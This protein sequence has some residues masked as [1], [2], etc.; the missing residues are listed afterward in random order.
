VNPIGERTK[1]LL[2]SVLLTLAS[3]IQALS[4]EVLWEGAQQA[5][6]LW[7]PGSQRLAGWLQVS[8][9][10]LA[11][12]LV[13]V[14]Y[15]QLV[16]R[17][18]WVPTLRDSAIPFGFGLGQFALGELLDPS[19]MHAWLYVVAGLFV[20]AAWASSTTLRVAEADPDN[21]WYFETFD[22]RLVARFGLAA[23]TVFSFVALG[24]VTQRIGAGGRWGIA[25]MLAA[26]ALL[27]GQL[28]VQRLY[29]NRSV[30]G[31]AD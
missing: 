11:V 8:A 4:L 9:T 26:N 24:L 2:P 21:A 1:E 31:R 20:Y 29:W 5:G 22:R 27:L 23:A 30:L 3:I 10:F 18:R 16:M 12:V 14:Y 17:F 7:V 13:W 19:R 25:A 15:A 6:H 28:A